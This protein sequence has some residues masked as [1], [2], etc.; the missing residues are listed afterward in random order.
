MA[1]AGL[2]VPHWNQ[3]LSKPHTMP[4]WQDCSMQAQH[5]RQKGTIICKVQR[6]SHSDP[7]EP[8]HHAMRLGSS[9]ATGMSMKKL[10]REDE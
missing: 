8:Q 10:T 5:R 9:S 7:P 2:Q 4:W 6:K 3:H 1:C